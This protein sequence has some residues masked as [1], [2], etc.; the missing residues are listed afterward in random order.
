MKRFR[1]NI[2]VFLL[3]IAY[4]IRGEIPQKKFSSKVD[5]RIQKWMNQGLQALEK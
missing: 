1:W 4:A 2:G 5:P 3:K